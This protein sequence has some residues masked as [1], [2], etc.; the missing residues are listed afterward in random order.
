M[1]TN[2][3]CKLQ[4]SFPSSSV[5]ISSSSS[6]SSPSSVANWT[7][8]SGSVMLASTDDPMPAVLLFHLEGHALALKESFPVEE[9]VYSIARSGDGA[10]AAVQVGGLN[11]EAVVTSE[12][13]KGAI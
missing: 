9:S 1:P 6:P 12:V 11:S 13:T 4:V 7:W 2:V 8:L 5:G 3:C 10:A